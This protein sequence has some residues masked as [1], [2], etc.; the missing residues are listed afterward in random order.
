MGDERW[1]AE[2]SKI[3]GWRI[4]LENE[5]A[6]ISERR[7]RRLEEG[8]TLSRAIEDRLE[9]RELECKTLLEL[10]SRGLDKRSARLFQGRVSL[11][12]RCRKKG[13]VL[14]RV[15]PTSMH[16]IVV[17]HIAG[18]DPAFKESRF[19]DVDAIREVRANAALYEE[20][21][22][23][24]PWVSEQTDWEFYERLMESAKDAAGRRLAYIRS[25][26]FSLPGMVVLVPRLR[27]KVVT[28]EGVDYEPYWSWLC[29]C[30]ESRY[31][32]HQLM[33]ALDEGVSQVFA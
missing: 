24:D 10:L 7:R 6:E 29:R 5:I 13:H 31:A 4:S 27:Q 15:Y 22:L 30:G 1:R 18:V 16:P 26:H 32:C 28:V 2:N 17:P 25:T 3:A 19:R 9:R 20:L 21:R 8:V 11:T 12:V 33:T 14:A 23:R